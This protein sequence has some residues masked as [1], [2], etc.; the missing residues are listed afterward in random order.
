MEEVD[1][2]YGTLS[3]V[4]S[5]NNLLIVLM[6]LFYGDSTIDR[7]TALAVMGGLDTD[8]NGATAGSITG[9]LNGRSQLAERLNDTV[10]P[11]FIGEGVCRMR[12]LA[13]RTL[14]VWKRIST[15]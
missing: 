7:N 13:A 8:C 6:A 3:G 12:D 1:R 5:I 4:H 10:E 15:R 11:Q 2:D 14:A 9:I